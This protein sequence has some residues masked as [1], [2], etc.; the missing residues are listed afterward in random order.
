MVDRLQLR[1]DFVGLER[2]LGEARAVGAFLLRVA[3]H[4][5]GQLVHRGR[6]DV[7]RELLAAP[8]RK[9]HRV[10]QRFDERRAIFG[11]GHIRA[12]R[13]ADFVRLLQQHLD[14]DAVDGVV[15]TVE[16]VGAHGGRAL[17]ESVDA[18]L[19]LLQFVGVPR[20]V[21]VDGGAELLL[22]VD[23]L[24][25]A[26]GGDQHARGV[27]VDGVHLQAS[28]VVALA[29]REAHHLQVGEVLREMLAEVVG[30]ILRRG[31]ESAPD[32]GH[33]AVCKQLLGESAAGVDFG[34]GALC[35]DLL[36][37]FGDGAQALLLAV[38]QRRPFQ[39]E[40][41]GF[42]FGQ[43]QAEVVDIVACERVGLL[44]VGG[45]VGGVAAVADGLQGGGGAGH[46]AAQQGERRPVVG[47]L[48]AVFGQLPALRQGAQAVV[49][50]LGEQFARQR[51]QRIG[52]VVDLARG[53][54]R[55]RPPL[56]LDVG[57]GAQH[58]VAGKSVAL[59][60][61][62]LVKCPLLELRVEQSQQFLE[63]VGDTAVG[64]GGQ[65]NQVALRLGRQRA[66][67]L[68]PLLRRHARWDG[69]MH[70]VHNHQLGTLLQKQVAVAL[71][72]DP[73]DADDQHGVMLVQ[74]DAAGLGAFELG[75]RAGVDHYGGQVELFG[76][77]ALP[78][79]AQ[80]RRAQ[81]R[82]AFDVAAL[83]QFAGDERG[84]DGLA[85]AH[86][87]GDEQAHGALAQRHQ[88][89]HELIQVRAYREA[90]HRAQRRCALAQH[91]ARGVPQQLHADRV[92][93]PLRARQ[94]EL[95]RRH[96]LRR[97]R[98]ADEVAQRTRHLDR[99][100]ARAR[101]RAQ[102]EHLCIAAGQQH[103]L[104]PA[105]AHD[106]ARFQLR[107]HHATS[108]SDYRRCR[109]IARIS[110]VARVFLP[111]PNNPPARASNLREA[112]APQVGILQEWL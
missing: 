21:V 38:G 5:Q 104:A 4:L 91:Q 3:A 65:Q 92:Q 16:A 97:Q 44:I 66:H 23:A 54:A 48:R 28:L 86:I 107:T 26:V 56:P 79:V 20:Q 34:V 112:P 61:R 103:P 90:S 32:D 13:F 63:G 11:H 71:R 72:F 6:V 95:R 50:G 52:E 78:L 37:D 105:T 31:D 59:R 101:Q 24:G 15:G 57:A 39:H 45:F 89:R 60:L 62:Q 98:V 12:E 1:A 88:Q 8:P 14:D 96:A 2:A 36:G 64:R 70:L 94:R 41:W 102:S 35:D 51:R 108:V 67:Q 10:H 46:H 80:I 25:E 99:F 69:V 49:V 85:H 110:T 83:P 84:F 93:H 106:R 40:R 7:E 73:I 43:A 82:Q 22:Q 68:I 42:V 17:P 75:E 18:P 27:G 9:E 19:A 55:G 29:S 58:E 47:A 100:I 81:H 77:L 87:V 74:V 76:Q 30:D 33:K 109:Q 53:K 111:P